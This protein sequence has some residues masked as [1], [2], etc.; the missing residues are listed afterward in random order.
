MGLY[1]YLDEGSQP[2]L[3]TLLALSGLREIVQRSDTTD[4]NFYYFRL[5]V[6]NSF[7]IIKSNVS[8]V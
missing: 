7:Q 1:D 4:V 6:V 3:E 2:W 5:L 8:I